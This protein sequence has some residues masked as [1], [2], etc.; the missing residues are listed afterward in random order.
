MI[1]TTHFEEA[2]KAQAE[3]LGFDPAIVYVPH[4]IQDRTDEEI[5]AIADVAFEP[6]LKM[7]CRA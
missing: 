1:A 3:A 2:A 5:R 7:I 6:V 4:P